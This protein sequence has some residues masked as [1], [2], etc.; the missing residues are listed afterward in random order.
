MTSL[1]R[2]NYAFEPEGRAWPARLL[3]QVPAGARVLE[4]G[5]GPGAMTRV[6]LERGHQV[7]VVENDTEALVALQA[8]GC[9]V[10]VADL[11]ES[12]SLSALAGQRFDVILAC[13]VLEHLL[14]PEVVVRALRE[15]IEPGGQLVVSVPNVAYAGVLASLR[16][17]LFDYAAKGILDCTHMRFFTRRSLDRMLLCEGWAV[18]HWESNRV[19]VERSE[20]VWSWQNLDGV[21]R[22]HLVSNWAD[23][24]VYQWMAVATPLKAAAVAQTRE[25]LAEASAAREELHALLM[26]HADEHASL[27]EH[28]KAFGEAKE[29]IARLEGEVQEL[30]KLHQAKDRA[31]ERK[32][33]ELH[34]AEQREHALE[35]EIAELRDSSFI[36]RMR[37]SLARR[38]WP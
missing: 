12:G 23:F 31:M 21:H 25:S 3:R 28:Q 6:L 22:Q 19:P 27:V 36:R 10:V 29:A 13:D 17:G 32:H 35:R 14:Q 5:P 34:L 11:N 18:H 2:Y 38:L 26:R 9:K 15:Q 8:L 24:D 30:L 1:N 4:L 7:T 33:E 20:F 16:C 37:R